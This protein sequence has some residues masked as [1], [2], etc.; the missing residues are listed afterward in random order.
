MSQGIRERTRMVVLTASTVLYQ[1]AGSNGRRHQG[2]T[3]GDGALQ[4]V[5]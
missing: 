4:S 5:S 2:G 1:E 3:G